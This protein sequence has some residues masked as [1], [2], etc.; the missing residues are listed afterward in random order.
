[1]LTREWTVLCF[2]YKLELLWENN[3]QQSVN[4]EFPTNMFLREVSMLVAPHAINDGDTGMV[5]IAGSMAHQRENSLYRTRS[6]IHLSR[7][8]SSLIS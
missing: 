2:D 3:V 5:L 1:M 8:R 7:L 6:Q 4:A